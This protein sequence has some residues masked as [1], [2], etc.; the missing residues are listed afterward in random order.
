VDQ[1]LLVDNRIDDGEKLLAQLVRSNFDVTV[2]FWVLE[3]EDT[4][5]FLYIASTNDEPETVG[6]AYR[7]L[8]V[9]LSKIPDISL[10]LSDVKLVHP[11]DPIAR[12]AIAARDRRPGRVPI[13]Y[14]GKRLG[15]I[16]IEE[17]FIYPKI[18]PMTRDEVRQTVMAL[19]NGQEHVNPSTFTFADGSTRQ[20][21]PIG[22]HVYSAGPTRGLQFELLDPVTNQHQ[23]VAA[24]EVINIQ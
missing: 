1:E 10:S 14:R 21:I 23:V 3:S 8:Y 9:A 24:D 2:A 5:S 22:M 4:S 13:R 20:A 17:A 16:D 19:L 18:G 7:K 12:D 6:D 11:S 15:N